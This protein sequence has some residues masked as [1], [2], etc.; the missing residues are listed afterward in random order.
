[1]TLKPLQPIE[2]GDRVFEPG[3]GLFEANPAELPGRE[4]REQIEPDV[5]RRSAVG[6]L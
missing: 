6:D 2:R 5:G 4:H 1:M 3:H